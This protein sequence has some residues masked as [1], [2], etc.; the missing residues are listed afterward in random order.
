MK[1]Q[2]KALLILLIMGLSSSSIAQNKPV[3]LKKT[4]IVKIIDTVEKQLLERYVDL[5]VAKQMSAAIKSNLASGD[6]DAITNSKAF[7]QKL[8]RDLQGISKDK[9][10]KLNFEPRRIANSKR[11]L[12]S[13]D[14]V[15]QANKMR[16]GMQRSNYG[17][18]V[19]K[20]IEGNIGYLN[21]KYFADAAIAKE[22]YQA[23]LAFLSNT[24][25]LII[26][27]RENGGGQPSTVKLLSSYFFE[28]QEVL[29]NTFYSR[30]NKET[31]EFRTAKEI[32]GKRLPNMKLFILTSEKTFSAAEAFAYN[33][34]HLNRALIIGETTRGGA[35]RSKRMPI[36]QNFSI[37]VPYVEAI[38]PIS[39]SNWE[40]VGVIPNIES[41]SKEAFALAYVEAINQTM[42]NHP[43]KNTILNRAGY[44]FLNR[45]SFTDAIGILKAN[46]ELHPTDANVWDSLGEAYLKAGHK[47]K[48]LQCYKKALALN[49]TLPSALELVN[50]LETKNQ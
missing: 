2:I 48:A 42:G 46:A 3:E 21:I 43:A 24:N 49:P 31:E 23:A 50:K 22:T 47:E 29:L 14:S 10:L 9:H 16:K 5:D 11:I 25:A 45:N 35:N 34:K 33:L 40:G 15:K 27:L 17:L 13:A 4:E 8:T 1:T 28:Q 32:D 12:S 26:D 41:T 39:K 44:S 20:V 37:S 30:F 7:A 18:Q 36:N 19:A 38:H 6:Y